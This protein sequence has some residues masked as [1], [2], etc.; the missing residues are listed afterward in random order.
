VIGRLKRWKN[1]L[2]LRTFSKAFGLAG[3]RIGYAVG[4]PELIRVLERLRAPFNVNRIAQIAAL[5]ALD[6]LGYVRRVVKKIKRERERLRRN[7]SS[8]GLR[9]FPSEANFLMVDVGTWKLKASE[10][11]DYLAEK[12]IFVRDLSGFRGAGSRYVRITV[13][14]P[15]ENKKLLIAIKQMKRRCLK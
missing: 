1:A 8:L 4:N 3:L 10:F 13:G 15:K 2:V 5:T 6:D 12:K 14:R 7:L 9:V 11:C